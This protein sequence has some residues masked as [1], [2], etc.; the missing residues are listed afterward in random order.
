MN[1]PYAVFILTHGRPNRVITYHNL[2]R[3]GYTGDIYL[4]VDNEDDTVDEYRALYGDQVI[5]FDKT[6]IS[7]TFDEAG[8][9]QDR[10][11]VVY[12]RNASFNIAR[13]LGIKY[14]IQMDDDYKEFTYYYNEALLYSY[15]LIKNLDFIFDAMW[16]YYNQIPALSIAMAQ[17]G[18][19]V[20]GK[21]ADMGK[22]IWMKRKVM[23]SFFCSVDRPFQFL[24]RVNEDVNTYVKLG[25]L[26]YLFG[27]INFVAL[28][29]LQTQQNKGGMSSL[30]MNEGTYVKSFYPILFSPS[31]V[32]IYPM[33]LK[34]PRLH[35]RISWNNAVP[36]IIHQK[37][38]RL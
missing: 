20:G 26:G 6:I 1:D 24:G 38:R 36:K 9:F 27:S 12:A 33:G 11:G 30:Y 29:Q 5:V 37:H 16:N 35:H 25:N 4:I 8:N 14:F 10:R 13:Q 19:F 17:R 23:N 32:K 3:C 7:K 18:D 22:E 21:E 28:N 2:R 34:Y 15:R 31:C